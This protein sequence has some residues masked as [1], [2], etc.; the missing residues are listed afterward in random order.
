MRKWHEEFVFVMLRI[1]L[2]CFGFLLMAGTTSAQST[3]DVEVAKLNAEMAKHY[4]KGDY[5]AALPVA[6]TIVELVTQ[7]FGKNHLRTA[8]ALKNRGFIENAKGDTDKAE[9]TLDDAVS[10]Y[11]K[12]PDLD[13]A[14]GASFAELLETLGAIRFRVR[15]PS[16]RSTLELALEWR[17]KINGPEATETAEPLAILAGLHFWNREYKTAAALYKRA[18]LILAK[19]GEPSNDDLIIVYYRTECTYRKAKIDAEFEPLKNTY[20]SERRLNSERNKKVSLINGGILNGKAIELKKPAY[21]V[22][23]R[24]ARASGAISV[25]VLI[26]EDGRILSACGIAEKAHPALIEASEIAAYNSRFSPT[27]LAGSPVKV[28]G[29][30][31]YNFVR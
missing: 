28:S 3:A 17:E 8:K 13:K 7:K 31:T 18:L 24:E 2:L 1:A 22:E 29:I 10:I 23:A 12:Y 26:S 27:T 19:N 25:Q 4:S 9:S 30:I 21:P 5:D 6:N 11:K 16:A 15:K 14:D 20:N